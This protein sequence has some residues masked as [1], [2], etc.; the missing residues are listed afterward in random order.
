MKTIV[1]TGANRGIGHGLTQQYLADQHRVIATVRSERGREALNGLQDQYADALVVHELDVASEASIS[2]FGEKLA[3]EALDGVINNAGISHEEPF[4]AWSNAGF[5]TNFAINTIG[6]ALVAQALVPRL[7]PGG[8]LI[9]MSSGMGSIQLK[10][11]PEGTLDAYAIS[12]GALNALTHRLAERWKPQGVIVAAISPGWVKTEMGGPD[13][14]TEVVDAVACL[15]RTFDALTA[16]Q[17]GLFMDE[18]GEPLPW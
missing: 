10:I 18:N 11:H 5:D 17:S 8:K 15:K 14:T 2:A 9:N 1:I 4:G 13:A 7:N 16:E 12:K 6:P 3:S